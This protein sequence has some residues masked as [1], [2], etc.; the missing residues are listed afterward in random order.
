MADSS[1]LPMS[2]ARFSATVPVGSAERIWMGP[3]RTRYGTELH[4]KSEWLALVEGLKG[5]PVSYDNLRRVAG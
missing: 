1:G 2:Y 3:L 5:K 4:S